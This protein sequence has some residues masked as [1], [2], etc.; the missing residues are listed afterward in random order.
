MR[1]KIKRRST[2]EFR[3]F[4]VLFAIAAIIF[5]VTGLLYT[6]RTVLHS[7]TAAPSVFANPYLRQN[8][9]IGVEEKL[10]KKGLAMES[11]QLSSNKTVL[12][13]KIQQGPEVILSSEQDIDWQIS[14][15][16]SIIYKLTIE[17]KQPKLIDFR[18]GKPIVKF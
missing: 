18:F 13:L 7:I 5:V 15:L 4:K 2:S 16:Q 14:S 3:I 11:S 12:T 8:Q 17:N 6:V 9:F 1:R 10:Y